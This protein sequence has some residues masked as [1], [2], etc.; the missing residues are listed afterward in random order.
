MAH[1][2][3]TGLLETVM[4]IPANPF[5]PVTSLSSLV[6]N[7]QLY[8][9]DVKV[10]HMIDLM[11]GLMNEL[12]VNTALTGLGLGIS[13]TGFF[14]VKKK[15]DKVSVQLG[16]IEETLIRLDA[17]RRLQELAN[18]E[19]EMDAQLAHAEEACGKP[20]AVQESGQGCPTS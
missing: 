14:M 15:L 6:S 2:Q 7:W 9:L 5:D 4:N 11:Q 1:L 16:R 19:A 10:D 13:V 8:R 20:M 18:L 3:E 12:F 17:E